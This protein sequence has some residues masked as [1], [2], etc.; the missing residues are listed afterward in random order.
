MNSRDKLIVVQEIFL[1]IGKL[2]L[3]TSYT[4]NLG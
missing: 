1:D 2:M 3:K 4:L